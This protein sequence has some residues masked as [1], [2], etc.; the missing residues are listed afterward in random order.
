MGAWGYRFWQLKEALWVRPLPATALSEIQAQLT[1]AEWALFQTFPPSDQRHSY[2]VMAELRQAGHTHPDLLTAA[3]L[4]DIGKTRLN[5]QVWERV[6]I[7]LAKRLLPPSVQQAWGAGAA[8]GLKRG[9]VVRAQHPAWGA[10]M[11]AAAG[12]RPLA[13]ELIRRHQDKGTA[14][15]SEADKL[16]QLLQ[17]ADDQN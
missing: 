8:R 15:V 9:L 6:W 14:V 12:G 3:L 7:V 10:E 16:L 2:R 13:V 4:H 1:P 17:W 5:L 11:V